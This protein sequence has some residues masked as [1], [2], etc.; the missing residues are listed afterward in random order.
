M[1]NIILF[2]FL[3][4]V[5]ATTGY[6]EDMKKPPADYQGAIAEKPKFDKGDRWEYMRRDKTI[7]HEFVGTQNETLVFHL[8]WDAWKDE[9]KKETEFRNADLNLIKVINEKGEEEVMTPYRGP[10]N[11]PLW[12]GKKWSYSFSSS[13]KVKSSGAGEL[14]TVDAH[15]KVVAYE[16]VKVPAGTF[17]AFKI[18]ETRQ[19]RGAKRGLAQYGTTITFWYSPEIKSIIKIEHA[20]DI[21]NREL[22]RYSPGSPH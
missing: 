2:L 4:F 10:F 19:N 17:R 3:V 16:Q 20:N 21:H 11:F 6:A 7:S 1:R 9:G 18:E 13:A 22:L 12:T 8:Q 5:T 14:V 15:V